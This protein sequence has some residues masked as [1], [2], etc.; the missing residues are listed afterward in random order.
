MPQAVQSTSSDDNIHSSK[1]EPKE[2]HHDARPHI[3][4]PTG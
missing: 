4:L 1:H 2:D 3:W